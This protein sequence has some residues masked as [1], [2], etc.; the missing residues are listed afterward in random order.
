MNCRRFHES[1]S[2]FADGL[3]DEVVEIEVRRHLAE[4]ACCR[5]FDA[6]FLAG[7]GALQ[8]L[9]PVSPSRGFGRRLRERLRHECGE[10]SPALGPWSG[11]AAALLVLALVSLAALEVRSHEEDL[12]AGA[13]SLLI[14]VPG[15]AMEAAV[16]QLADDSTMS[17]G[18]PFRPFPTTEGFTAMTLSG[19]FASYAVLT[20]R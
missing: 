20:S 4:C 1:F 18:N 8:A 2:D 7:R 13:D 16:V 6:A 19:Q 5:R 15:A 11:A 12:A 10:G 17:F 9:P 3:L 14:Q